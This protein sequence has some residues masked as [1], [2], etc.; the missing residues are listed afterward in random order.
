MNWINE[1]IMN[2]DRCMTACT[3]TSPC[4]SKGSCTSNCGSNCG[5]YC[6]FR[7][8]AC[9][10]LAQCGTYLYGCRDAYYL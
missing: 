9:S 4:P 7:V 1:S 2:N 3:F 10:S 6:G 8:T 5:S